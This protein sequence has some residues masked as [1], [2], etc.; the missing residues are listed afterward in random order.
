LGL[1]RYLSHE[2]NAI[3]NSSIKWVIDVGANV[4]DF[5]SEYCYIKKY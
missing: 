1:N 4:K 3:A 5:D 2:N